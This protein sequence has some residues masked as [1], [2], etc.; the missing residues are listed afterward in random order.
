MGTETAIKLQGQTQQ[1]EKIVEDLDQIH[2]SLKRARRLVR[3][4]ARQ[5]ATD[6]CIMAF[7]GLIALGVLAIVFVKVFKPGGGGGSPSQP[8]QE[9]VPT[10]DNRRLLLVRHNPEVHA[11]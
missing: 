8:G 7:L 10:I 11:G 1:M 2:F 3:D 9:V 5:L 4:I 6:K